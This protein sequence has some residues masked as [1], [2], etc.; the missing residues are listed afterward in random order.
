MKGKFFL[1][2]GYCFKDIIN[3][4]NVTKRLIKFSATEELKLVKINDYNLFLIK[5]SDRKKAYEVGILIKSILGIYFDI[6]LDNIHGVYYLQELIKLPPNKSKIDLKTILKRTIHYWYDDFLRRQLLQGPILDKR[7]LKHFIDLFTRFYY[8]GRLSESISHLLESVT[9]YDVILKKNH[10]TAKIFSEAE[11]EKRYY[12]NRNK[13][14]LS[15][16]SSFKG[17]ERIFDVN[18]IKKN[19]IEGLLKKYK[20]E[21]EIYTRKFDKKIKYKIAYAQLIEYFLDI[22]NAAAAHGN[23]NP[24]PHCRVNDYNIQEIRHFLMEII[25]KNI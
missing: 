18:D 16:L 3:K 20:M 13:F 7:Q 25:E 15:F 24:P 10:T 23:K 4:N 17:L 8:D 9:T 12:E 1:V 21:K 5:A 14:E 11:L 6:Y 22:R 19:E 2:Y